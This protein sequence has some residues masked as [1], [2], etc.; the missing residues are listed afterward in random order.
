MLAATGA[1][2]VRMDVGWGKTERERGVY[3]FSAIETLLDALDKHDLRA[4]LILDY[5][6][7]LYSPVSPA[8]DESRA[9][10]ARWAGAVAKRFAGRGVLW[11]IWNEPNIGFWRPKPNVNDYMALAR[12][13]AKTIKAEAPGEAIVGP[14]GAYFDWEFLEACFR[15][16]LLEDVDAVTVHPYRMT[17]PDTAAPDW[18]R[19]REMI[20]QYKP[21]NKD[22]P[23]LSGEWGYSSSVGRLTNEQQARYL[24]RQW[25][26]NLASG[27]P[28]SIWYDW[29]DDGDDPKQSEHRYGTV[30]RA[31]LAGQNPPFKP[32]PAYFAAQ[33]LIQELRGYTFR[34][35]LPTGD[36]GDWVTVFGN[37]RGETKIAAWTKLGA[38][39]MVD[40]NYKGRSLHLPLT[41]TPNYFVV[42][43]DTK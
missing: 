28:L 30:E 7:K 42:M 36:D 29:R 26:S 14:A 32:K 40:V 13:T 1:K 15:L 31:Y 9:A 27:V 38:G 2:W 25:L 17:A 20:E 12:L 41:T 37:A 4:I 23:I 11:E 24:S 8:T 43:K 5:G 16:G 22:I 34:E 6:N 18:K 10:F 19:L 39:K 21:A 33:H 35:R 3:D